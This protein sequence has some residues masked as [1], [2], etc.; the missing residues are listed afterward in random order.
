MRCARVTGLKQKDPPAPSVLNLIGPGQTSDFPE[1]SNREFEN[2]KEGCPPSF[3][4]DATLVFL[5]DSRMRSPRMSFS[6]GRTKPVVVENV[7]R[8]IAAP[9]ALLP[10][11]RARASQCEPVLAW[12]ALGVEGSRSPRRFE[13]GAGMS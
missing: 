5:G 1:G 2:E 4:A 3:L 11:S 9:T 12:G 8:R 10:L 13:S 6:H 7:K